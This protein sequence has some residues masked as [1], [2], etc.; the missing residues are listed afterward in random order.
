MIQ[1][2]GCFIAIIATSIMLEAPKRTLLPAALLGAFVWFA[3][4]ELNF[5]S[6]ALRVFI[7]GLIISAVAQVLSRI[8]KTPV[9][10]FLIPCFYPLVPGVALYKTIFFL[11]SENMAGFTQNL[12]IAALT[13]G[14]LA[15]SV[16]TVDSIM[17]MVRKI[18]AFNKV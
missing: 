8:F 6:E 10:I 11:I 7:C 1:I 17:G 4:L 9:T 2:I 12:N 3:Y 5:L 18:K 16:F 15:L 13:A 14:M